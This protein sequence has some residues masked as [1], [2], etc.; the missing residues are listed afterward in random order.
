M[1]FVPVDVVHRQV[2][3]FLGHQLGSSLTL[4]ALVDGSFL[5]SY[6]EL[7]VS[8]LGAEVEACRTSLPCDCG[9]IVF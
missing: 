6:Q 2:V 7:A 5:S 4:G 9:F 3:S 1:V 8:F